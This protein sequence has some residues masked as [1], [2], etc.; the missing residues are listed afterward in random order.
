M[1]VTLQVMIRLLRFLL[2]VTTLLT[3]SQG[4]T[5]LATDPAAS[6]FLTLNHLKL[7][8]EIDRAEFAAPLA[9]LDKLYL[10]RSRN[11]SRCEPKRHGWKS[12]ISS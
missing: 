6:K 8:F 11:S 2:V 4:M 12:V 9:R 10:V 3:H 5:Q 1:S 7:E